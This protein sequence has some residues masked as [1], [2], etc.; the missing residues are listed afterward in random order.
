MLIIQAQG[1]NVSRRSFARDVRAAAGAIAAAHSA[2]ARVAPCA[3]A[4]AH[5]HFYAAGAFLAQ[6]ETSDI[7]NVRCEERDV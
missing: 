4:D 1:P 3:H 5:A 7:L 2:T 6:G